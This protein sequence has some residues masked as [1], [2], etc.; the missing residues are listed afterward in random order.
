MDS[1]IVT[2]SR[3]WM[4]R[5]VPPVA[6]GALA[7]SGGDLYFS[8]FLA[9]ALEPPL[10]SVSD[11]LFLSFYPA[12]YGALALLVRRNV[13]EFHAS[14]WLDALLGALAVSAVA[15]ALLYDAVSAG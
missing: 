13:S 11:A 7:W 6:L 5:T 15:A 8:L 4:G 10:P 1:N 3:P 2:P 9:D 14:L 12:A